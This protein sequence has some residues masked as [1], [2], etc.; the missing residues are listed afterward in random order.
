MMLKSLRV[1]QLKISE[2]NKMWRVGVFLKREDLV[3]V[4]FI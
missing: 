1:K 4:L 3:N 2:D